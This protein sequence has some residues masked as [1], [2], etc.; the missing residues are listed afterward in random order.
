M[1]QT[2][3]QENGKCCVDM[4]LLSIEPEIESG[5]LRSGRRFRSG[6]RRKTEEGRRAPILFEESDHELRSQVYEGYSNKEEDYSPILEGAEDFEEIVKTPRSGRNYIT[7]GVSPEVRSRASSLERIV[8]TDS[9]S[10]VT[11]AQEGTP[12]LEYSSDNLDANSMA[13]ED[14]RLPKF[15]GNCYSGFHHAR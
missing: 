8:N 10:V 2:S 13:G 11:T 3:C 6:K 12:P 1:S 5:F 4:F 9:A 14:I 15:N 7:P